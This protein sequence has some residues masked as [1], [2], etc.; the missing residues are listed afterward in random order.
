MEAQRD[1][2]VHPSSRRAK[3]PR[4][5]EGDEF[6]AK[7]SERGSI[8]GFAG[9]NAGSASAVRLRTSAGRPD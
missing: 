3:L 8:H 5:G 7:A 6:R 9:W 2:G 4:N 1:I